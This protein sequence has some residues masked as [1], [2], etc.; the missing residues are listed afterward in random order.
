[1]TTKKKATH[2]AALKNQHVN[3]I[4][5]SFAPQCPYEARLI[6]R[7]IRGRCSRSELDHAIGTTNAPEYVRRLRNRGLPIHM[8]WERGLNRDGRC[9]R[10]GVYWLPASC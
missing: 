4:P 5:D 8:D 7:L 3:N 6:A 9:I 10:Y 1:M 2:E